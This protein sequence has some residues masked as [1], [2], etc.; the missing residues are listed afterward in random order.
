M[1]YTEME[2]RLA[3]NSKSDLLCVAKEYC[4]MQ[5]IQPPDRLCR[6]YREAVIRFYSQ[7]LPQFPE[8]CPLIPFCLR[9]IPKTL[10]HVR[11]LVVQAPRDA[12]LL[13][14]QLDRTWNEMMNDGMHGGTADW[15]SELAEKSFN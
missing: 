14:A 5:K 7:Y 13:D 3:L 4:R 15:G 10:N 2:Q 6:R 9:P 8:G 11:P 12:G 1:D